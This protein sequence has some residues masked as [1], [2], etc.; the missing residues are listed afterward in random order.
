MK[1]LSVILVLI[2]SIIAVSGCG[3]KV[4][5]PVTLGDDN[6]ALKV[7]MAATGAD[8][9]D[10][11]FNQGAWEGLKNAHD[12]VG[13]RVSYIESE[14]DK[15]Y[16]KSLQRLVDSGND[17][18]WGIGYEFSDV[19][20]KAAEKYPNTNFAILDHVYEDV[21]QNVTCAGFRAEESAFLVGYIAASVTGTGKIGLI[22]GSNASPLNAFRYGYLAGAKTASEELGK[23]ISVDSRFI[24]TFENRD[25]G[26][27]AAEEMYSSG[28]DVIFQAAGG[29]GVGVIN[30]AKDMNKYVIGVDCDQTGLAPDNVLTCAL[31][32]VDEAVS[33]I[34]VQYSI[35]EDIGG[36]VLEYGLAEHAVGIPENHPNISDE[37]YNKAMELQDQIIYGEITVPT[38]EEEVQAFKAGGSE[39]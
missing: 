19:I 6:A 17:L 29:A 22:G 20:L 18:C 8:I 7:G 14:T 24:D 27:S 9:N 4:S 23:D 16:Y 38:N 28:C 11:S 26:Y 32:K 10:N 15:T 25:E 5:E 31:K 36:K 35:G 21:P 13:A 12:S 37:L 34:S 39:E 33:N 2:M 3:K 1:K 30:A